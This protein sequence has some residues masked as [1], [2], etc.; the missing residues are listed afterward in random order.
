[1]AGDIGKPATG[2]ALVQTAE[3]EFGGLDILMNNAG[4]FR[5]KPFDDVA[6]EEYD[7]SFDTILKGKFFTAQAAAN[8]CMHPLVHNLAL[9]L[10]PDKIRIN[11]VAPEVVS[12][13]RTSRATHRCRGGLSS[14]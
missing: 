3:K 6:E 14:F 5:P 10:A 8:A 1:M 11:A 12:S 9:E 4:V 2:A 13:S 7:W